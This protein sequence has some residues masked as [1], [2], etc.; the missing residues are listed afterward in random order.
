MIFEGKM[1]YKQ[2]LPQRH[3]IRLDGYDYSRE[4]LYF[5]TVCTKDK[6][7]LFG[8]VAN[9]KMILNEIGYETEKCWLAISQHFPHV[10]LHEYLIMPNHIHGIIEITEIVGANNHSPEKEGRFKSPSKTIGSIIRGFKIGVIKQIKN[11]S[12]ANGYS[13]L[14]DGSIWQRNYYE[15]IIRNDESYGKITEYIYENPKSWD[16][17]DYYTHSDV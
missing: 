10:K 6:V 1:N 15:H 12:R 16:R 17:D 5:V 7:Y 14:Q 2:N 13:P 9:E 8:S 4:G 11:I 3:S